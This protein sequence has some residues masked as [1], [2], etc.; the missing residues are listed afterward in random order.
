MPA[1]MTYQRNSKRNVKI[2][3]SSRKKFIQSWQEKRRAAG[4][5]KIEETWND[6]KIFWGMI[7]EL[8]GK[9]K[10]RE[11]EAYVYTEEGE[12]REIMEIPDKFLGSWQENIYQKATRPD[13]SFW[14]GKGGL[15]EK[16]LEEE[17]KQDS[18]IM[19]FPTIEETELVNVINNM[20]NGKASDIDG[21]SA[22]LMKILIKD[23]RIR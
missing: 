1:R 14:H 7:K 2:N 3:M 15:M 17:K 13:F 18:G 9:K 11:E 16:M 8:L 12:R 21:I 10:E 22:E 23:E 4:K 20:K 6:G 5:K 19:K